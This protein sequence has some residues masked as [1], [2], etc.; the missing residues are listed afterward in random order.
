[1]AESIYHRQSRSLILHNKL[2]LAES[3]CH[4]IRSYL[5]DNCE[6][7]GDG[8]AEILI[9]QSHL[10]KEPYPL[11]PYSVEF[12]WTFKLLQARILTNKRGQDGR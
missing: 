12:W 1:M 3:I 6:N 11:P 9:V 5:S 8:F 10:V 4:V 2:Q 7:R